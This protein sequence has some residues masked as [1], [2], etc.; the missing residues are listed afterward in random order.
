MDQ[1]LPAALLN[2]LCTL[3]GK[4]LPERA[5]IRVWGMS[6]VERVTF[7]DGTTTVFKYAKDPFDRE[8]QALRVAYQRGLPVPALHATTMQDKWLGMLMDDLGTPVRDADD[9]DGVAAAVMLHAARPA[10]GLPLLDG[11]GLA[12]LPGRALDHLQRLRKTDR[13][14]DCDDIKTAL[15]EI[16]AAAE[17][18]VQGATLDPF[19]WVHSEFHPTSVHIGENGWH[20]LDFARAFTGPGLIDLASYHGT[21]DVPSPFRLRVLLEQYVTAGGHEDAL[22]ARGGL[23]PEAWALG[24]HRMWAVEWFMEQAIRWIDDPAKDPAYIPVVRRHLNDVVQ[25]LEV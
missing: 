18:R 9:L 17:A 7:P 21:T 24:W 15:G 23:A 12:A 3:V 13:W 11:A 14:T 10:G 22:A 5:E 6:G 19:G 1:S 2:D 8:A 20:L 4:P 25:L 16:S